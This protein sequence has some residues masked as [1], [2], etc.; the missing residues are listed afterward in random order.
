MEEEQKVDLPLNGELDI[1]SSDMLVSVN[2]AKLA[3]NRQ[4]WQGH[5]LPSS[6]RYEHDGWA[7]GWDVYNLNYTEVTTDVT[8]TNGV[9]YKIRRYYYNDNKAYSIA[10]LSADDKPVA[11]FVYN[12]T[13]V[14]PI[15][16]KLTHIERSLY[17]VTFTVDN[18]DCTFI[19]DTV[20]NTV[21]DVTEGYVITHDLGENCKLNVIAKDAKNA[22]NVDIKG[23]TL[24]STL[25]LCIG[26]TN[27]NIGVFDHFG[28]GKTQWVG[29]KYT[30]LLSKN[31]DTYTLNT[32]YNGVS[33]QNAWA[34]VKVALDPATGQF[35]PV[36]G[37]D[38]VTAF[39]L[40]GS[41]QV[42]FNG[43]DAY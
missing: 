32:K 7:A 15:G 39:N 22:I 35:K 26:D 16:V 18:R 43:T 20:L 34:D 3:H 17:S 30:S 12:M 37:S 2:D 19:Y 9:L 5:C 33:T 27:T 23:I 4:R 14:C 28:E 1:K 29:T 11:S 24:P 38:G 42:E 8:S 36:P 31:N 10:I 25:Q 40:R 41:G 6:L 13:T 21:T